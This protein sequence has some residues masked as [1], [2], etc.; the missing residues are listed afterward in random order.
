MTCRY[1]AGGDAFGLPALPE[2]ARDL[3]A[4]FEQDTPRPAE[5][6]EKMARDP[7]LAARVLAVA[8]SPFYGMAQRIGSVHEACMVLGLHQVRALALAA[9]LVA[10]S[11]PAL[12]PLWRHAVQTA[13]RARALVPRAQRDAAFVAGLLHDVGRLVIQVGG[14]RA[15]EVAAWQTRETV[16]FCAA[17]RAVLGCDH[18]AI[19]ASAARTWRL[20]EDIVAAIRDHHGPPPDA[21]PLSDAV[22]VAEL[23]STAGAGAVAAAAEARAALARLGVPIETF[24]GRL[25]AAEEASVLAAIGP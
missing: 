23:W 5:V 7:A 8:N 17:E 19:G 16:D 11:A 3:L 21:A 12:R 15:A 6:A 24:A 1:C 4:S 10:G 13:L 2:I 22:Y 9:S 25:N 14:D 20:P 18:A